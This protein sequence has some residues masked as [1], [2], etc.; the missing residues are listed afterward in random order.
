MSP[1]TQ[2]RPLRLCLLSREYAEDTPLGGI[3]RIVNMQ[4]K[5]LA[6]AGV[7]VHVLTLSPSGRT[8]YVED[9]VHVH[10]YPGPGAYHEPD[11]YYLAL[12]GWSKVAADAFAD[13]DA[14]TPIDVVDTPDYGA[15]S[16]HLALRDRTALVTTL[17]GASALVEA[18]NLLEAPS[19]GRKV[20]YELE[21]LGVRRA[22]LVIAPTR[23]I[24]RDVRAL[25]G[26]DGPP[27][28]VLP[29]AFDPV[30]FP[31]R[32][33]R[34]PAPGVRRLL[35]T[36]R[37]EG[38]KGVDFALRAAAAVAARGYDT[39]LVVAGRDWSSYRRRVLEPLSEELGFSGVRYLGEV[40]E[41]RVG[42]LLREADCVIMPSRQENFHMAAN[43]ALASGTPVITSD[44]NGVTCWYEREHGML[45]L[46]LDDP[47][48]FAEL[49][50]DAI[51]DEDWL[52]E[53]GVRGAERVRTLLAPDRIGAEL[54]ATYREAIELKV[55]ASGAAPEVPATVAPALP[56]GT[57][58][59][60]AVLADA[61]ELEA[62]PD[63][64][65]AYAAAVGGDDDATLVVVGTTA[66]SGAVA[67]AL[68]VVAETA[69]GPPHVV[70]RET[71]PP[72]EELAAVLTE[73]PPVAARAHL[74]QVGVASAARLRDLLTP[75]LEGASA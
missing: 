32:E 7:E 46:A 50:A 40:A 72:A 43:E 15:E 61:A 52:A 26:C 5:I 44:V 37:V 36:G 71:A 63:L 3:G 14:R 19:P 30:R 27:A 64:L 49:A 41:R 21:L 11:Q 60:L 39:E 4:A 51:A 47:Q 75:A 25:M 70:G 12:A 58:R 59:G 13:L 16:L 18:P 20:L 73:A 66:Q 6:A 62:R 56:A 23:V 69:A 48:R 17:H 67:A 33:P 10:R 29:H 28:K 57:P 22:D 9:G 24:L 45:A 65:G 42:E 35:F 74:P 34:R 54:V 53:S 31:A 8:D 68:D 55:A 1:T 38:R 2:D